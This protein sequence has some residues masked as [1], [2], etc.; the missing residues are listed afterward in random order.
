MR[1][2]LRAVKATYNFF[3]GDLFILAGAIAAFVLARLLLILTTLPNAVVA[4]IYIALIAGGLTMSLG[5][6]VS[7]RGNV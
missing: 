2:V 1:A 3:A 4:V 7:G 6:E 5:H